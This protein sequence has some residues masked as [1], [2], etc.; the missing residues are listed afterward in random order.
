MLRVPSMFITPQWESIAYQSNSDFE[1]LDNLDYDQSFKMT[2]EMQ[3]FETVD[4]F[5][6]SSQ[7][8]GMDTF[9]NA[10]RI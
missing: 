4:I 7:T 8:N 2:K 5:I 3:Y 9:R 6:D 1:M 10:V